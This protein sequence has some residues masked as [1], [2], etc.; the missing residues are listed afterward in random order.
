[1]LVNVHGGPTSQAL[2]DWNPRVQYLV[3]RGW[4]VLQP[5]Y[6]GST[7][8]GMTYRR[9]LE[10]RWGERDAADVAAGIKH[11]VKEGWC[12]PRRVVLMGGSA[13]GLTILN[14][15]ALHGDLV[16]AVVALYPVTD[17][18]ELDATTHRFESGYNAR[19]VGPL[20][21]ARD[22]YVANSATTHATKITA[23]A[24][25]LHGSE[26]HIVVPA[27]S[28]ALEQTLQR[29]G[30]PVERH[31]YEGEGH[32]WRRSGTVVDELERI[33]AFLARTVG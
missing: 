30:T 6:R 4:I 29:A 13:G 24:L 25:L 31:V 28:A 20:P 7:G 16:A 12:D 19:L 1:M 18:L 17:L 27:Q 23:P 14:V 3:Q 9:A 15:A 2:A 22:T 8:Y 21:D 5:N 11:A 10:G 33:E 32:G 26:D